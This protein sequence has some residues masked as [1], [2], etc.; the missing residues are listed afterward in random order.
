MR[1]EHGAVRSAVGG[2]RPAILEY[3]STRSR[4]ARGYRRFGKTR[5]NFNKYSAYQRA[6]SYFVVFLTSWTR[7][8]EL[9]WSIAKLRPHLRTSPAM[10]AM[11]T[12]DFPVCSFV[13]ATKIALPRSV[14]RIHTQNDG[15]EISLRGQMSL[16]ARMSPDPVPSVGQPPLSGPSALGA[17]GL[18]LIHSFTGVQTNSE[19]T[20]SSVWVIKTVIIFTYELTSPLTSCHMPPA[21]ISHRHTSTAE[22]TKHDVFLPLP[23]RPLCFSK[24]AQQPTSAAL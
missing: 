5:N 24:Q 13:A 20:S 21:R 17:S 4:G 19:N 11:D 6:A 18:I 15:K 14:T 12:D 7:R 3:A 23:V 8:Y 9:P 1:S 16:E 2:L 22:L 10:S